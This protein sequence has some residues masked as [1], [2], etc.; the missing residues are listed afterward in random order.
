MAQRT[1]ADERDEAPGPNVYLPGGV[2]TSFDGSRFDSIWAALF[3][4]RV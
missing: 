1:R 3:N 2:P 4:H